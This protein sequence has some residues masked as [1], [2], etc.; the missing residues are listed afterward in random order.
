MH[1]LLVITSLAAGGAER[2]MSTL[3]TSWQQRGHEV[4]LVTDASPETDHFRVPS[5]VRRVSFNAPSTSWKSPD[6]LT[7]N[8]LR[9]RRLRNQVLASRPDIIISFGDTTNVR[10]VIASAGLGI[11]VIVSERTDPR[12]NPL[13]W[14]W[15]VLRRLSYPQAALLV[16]QTRSVAEWALAFVDTTRIAVIPNPVRLI[17]NKAKPL[18]EH[19][20]SGMVIAVGR[21]SREK[22][23]DLLLEAFA[24]SRIASC[25]WKIAILGEGP[26]RRSL[27]NLAHELGISSSLVMPG[28]V[29]SPEAWLR[30]ADIFVLSSRFEGFPNALLEAMTCGLPVVSF[31]CPSGPAEIVKHATTGLLIPPSSI[32][33]LSNALQRLSEDS[34]LRESLGSAGERDVAARFSLDHVLGLWD[35]VLLRGREKWESRI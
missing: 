21:L 22:G 3:A 17:E 24:R 1:L 2:V 14:P 34:R 8:L 9:I 7:R 16:V 27:T 20:G 30:M 26:E 13:P 5:E 32:D 35:Q 19:G 15:R 29:E 18:A 28:V 25:G 11:P 6:R 33:E 23:F 31:D 10:T 4:T 12:R